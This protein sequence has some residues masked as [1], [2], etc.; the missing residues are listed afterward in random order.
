MIGTIKSRVPN[1]PY[2]VYKSHDCLTLTARVSPREKDEMIAGQKIIWF[3]L[4]FIIHFMKFHEFKKRF[5]I[6]CIMCQQ[7]VDQLFP[8]RCHH[9]ET[10]VTPIVTLWK[11][12]QCQ[13]SV[14]AIVRG[15]SMFQHIVWI[16][17]SADADYVISIAYSQVRKISKKLGSPGTARLDR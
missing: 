12:N 9:H 14:F 5:F 17:P 2:F 10:S 16:R 3:H 7:P 8:V 13:K 1:I 15:D 11:L 6:I 4:V